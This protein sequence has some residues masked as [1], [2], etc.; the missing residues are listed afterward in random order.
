L[1]TGTALVLYDGHPFHPRDDLIWRIAEKTRATA[2][3]LSPG[4][5]ARQEQ[6]GMVPGA[7]FDLSALDHIILGGAP[8]SPETFKWCYENIK[9]DLWVVSQAGSTEICSSLVGGIV[10]RPV[11]AGEIQGRMLGIAID[12]FSDDGRPIR[13]VT[14]ELVVKAPFPSMPLCL[15]NDP[16]GARFH[17][18]YFSCFAGVWRQGDFFQV[19]D[20]GGCFIYGR[21]DATMNRYG[22]RIGTSEIYRTLANIPQITDSI[23]ICME[24]ERTSAMLLFVTLAPG[25]AL[26]DELR[27]HIQQALQRENSARHIPDEIIAAPAI[28]YTASGKRM[29]VPL[30]RVLSGETLQSS[31]N[32]DTMADPKALDWFERFTH[33]RKAR[34]HHAASG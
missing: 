18:A 10:S 9:P 32:R 8:S 11:Y 25:L 3:G 14:G 6:A 17:K 24:A 28:P 31:A 7:Q 19:N 21:S 26:D 15:W 13:N 16:L 23:V 30:K 27:T 34:S 5:V 2:V 33:M 1:V 20:R 29:E 22:V 4:L 12:C